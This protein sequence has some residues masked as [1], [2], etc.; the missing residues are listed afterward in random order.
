MKRIVLAFLLAPVLVFAQENREIDGS[1]NN[2]SNGDWGAAETQFL[3][4]TSGQ[5]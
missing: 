3:R 4:Y 2:L 1:G 5:L